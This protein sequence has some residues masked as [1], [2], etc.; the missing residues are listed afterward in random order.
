MCIFK[1]IKKRNKMKKIFLS[2]ILIVAVIVGC[3]TANS[4]DS[5]KLV[6]NFEP[7]SNS[8]VSGIATFVE[9]NGLQKKAVLFFIPNKRKKKTNKNCV[10]I[11]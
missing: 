3:K 10:P 5:K 9:K 11:A 4:N 2:I 7:K 6:L 1:Q 8:T